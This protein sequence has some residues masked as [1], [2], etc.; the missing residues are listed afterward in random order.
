MRKSFLATSA[1][2]GLVLTN[3]ASATEAQRAIYPIIQQVTSDVRLIRFSPD[4]AVEQLHGKA[5]LAHLQNLRG[6]RPEAFKKAIETL[7][8]KGRTS[9]DEVFVER[10]LDTRLTKGHGITI[11]PY[12]LVQTSSESSSQGEIVFWS[13]D[14]PGY[15]WQGT[16]YMEVYG[17]GASTWDGEIDTG[18]TEYPWDWVDQTWASSDCSPHCGPDNQGRILPLAPGD[19][20]HGAVELASLRRSGETRLVDWNSWYNWSTCWR[21]NV[22]GGCTTAAAVCF[23]VK[24]TF[25]ACWAIGCVGVEIGYGIGCAF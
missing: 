2:L 17:Y 12:S 21:T 8:N 14:G 13:W 5:A 22:I 9:T 1:V 24:A 16:I 3:S 18:S 11:S 23:R 4:V 19:M 20:T 25:P 6:R 10:T 15:T 7:K